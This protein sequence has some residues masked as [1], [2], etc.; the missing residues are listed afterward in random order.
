MNRGLILIGIKVSGTKSLPNDRYSIADMTWV[1][2]ILQYSQHMNYNNV[3]PTSIH[4]RYFLYSKLVG[5]VLVILGLDM[6]I[7]RHL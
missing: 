6:H 4:F 1:D 5:A 3:L 2:T 7:S